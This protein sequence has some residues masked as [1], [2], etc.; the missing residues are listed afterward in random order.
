MA[1][2]ETH[3][4]QFTLWMRTQSFSD[5]TVKT[6]QRIMARFFDY[7]QERGVQDIK[8]VTPSVVSQYQ[9]YLSTQPGLK[10]KKLS[11]STQHLMMTAVCCFF[12]AMVREGRLLFDPS[13]HIEFP[14]VRRNL[15]HDILTF[16]ETDVLLNAPDPEKPIELRDKAILELFYSSGL[17]NSELRNLAVNDVDLQERLIRIRHAKGDKER[18]I[19]VGRIAASYIEEY[20]RQVRPKLATGEATDVLFLSNRGRRLDESFPAHIV[21][22]YARRGKIT[23]RVNAHTMRHTCATH[24]LRCKAPLR[25]IQELLGHTSL[26]TTQIYTQVEPLDLKRIHAQTHPREKGLPYVEVG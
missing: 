13:S 21:Q 22:K 23:R 11:L 19:P 2:A 10:V 8:D 5:R 26:N 17:R 24:L 6:Y 1:A 9:I 4:A 16:K 12:K 25:Y 18:V 14:R 7:L 20:L 15:P 3:L